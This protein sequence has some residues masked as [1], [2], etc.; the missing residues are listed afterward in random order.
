M[1]IPPRGADFRF[2]DE[3]RL[4]VNADVKAWSRAYS[5]LHYF[6]VDSGKITCGRYDNAVEIAD[7]GLDAAKHARCGNYADDFGHFLRPGY[8]V[9]FQAMPK[10]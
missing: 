6:E 7:A 3:D 2:R 10:N 1:G 5:F 4:A 9:I 8:D